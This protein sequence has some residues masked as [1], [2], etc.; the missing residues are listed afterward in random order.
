V[1]QLTA[2]IEEGF[3]LGKVREGS[4]FLVT[5]SLGFTLLVL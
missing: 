3:L 2:G 5:S 4:F 1:G